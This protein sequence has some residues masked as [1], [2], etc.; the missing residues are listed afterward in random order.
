MLPSVSARML[1]LVP[2]SLS[3]NIALYLSNSDLLSFSKISFKISTFVI[4]IG[5]AGS[6][7]EYGFFC[8]FSVLLLNSNH[9]SRSKANSQVSATSNTGSLRYFSNNG[10]TLGSPIAPSA[11]PVQIIDIEMYTYIYFLYLFQ[12]KSLKIK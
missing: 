11:S 1:S 3:E 7:V 5:G 4:S 12:N 6:M 8:K 2:K 10:I 9:F